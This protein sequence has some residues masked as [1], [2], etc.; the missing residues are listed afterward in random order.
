MHTKFS[1][2]TSLKV[3]ARENEEMGSGW[4]WLKFMSTVGLWY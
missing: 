2:E 3:K 1:K 4:N